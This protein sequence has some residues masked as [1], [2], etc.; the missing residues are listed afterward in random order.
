[1]E[2]L[3]CSAGNKEPLVVNSVD[4]RRPELFMRTDLHGTRLNTIGGMLNC[5]I[6]ATPVD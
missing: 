2:Y 3:N 6:F 5:Q 1:V 4:R